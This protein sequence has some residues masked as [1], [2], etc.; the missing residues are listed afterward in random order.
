MEFSEEFV[1][2]QGALIT[3]ERA[4]GELQFLSLKNGNNPYMKSGLYIDWTPSLS[5]NT[6]R[7]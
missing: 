4:V 2:V 6:Y 5:I 1:V 7:T 3:A